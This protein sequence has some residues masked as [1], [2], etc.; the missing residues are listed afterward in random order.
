MLAYPFFVLKFKYE[1]LVLLLNYQSFF[2]FMMNQQKLSR[3]EKER[4][5]RRATIMDAAV[6]FFAQKGY[7]DTTLDEIA[8]TAEFGKGTIYN[9]FKSKED[10]YSAIIDDVSNNLYEITQQA[11]QSSDSAKEF[12]KQHFKLLIQYCVNNRNAFIIY[13]REIAQFTTD[14]FITDRCKI[15][16]RHGKVRSVLVKKI[17]EGISK[18]EF[19]KYDPEKLTTLYEHLVFPYILFLIN[20]CED[21]FDQDKEIEFILSVFYNGIIFNSKQAK[22]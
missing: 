3:K 12:F 20:C 19:K 14:I 4:L 2:L 6:G 10:I 13:V 17:K 11:N 22:R 16:E 21:K 7:R 5:F 8:V 1:P 15:N 18:K 9:Y